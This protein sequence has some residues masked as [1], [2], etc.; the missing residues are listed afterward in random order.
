M[1]LKRMLPRAARRDPFKYFSKDGPYILDRDHAARE[2]VSRIMGPDSRINDEL[3]WFAKV[4]NLKK[5]KFCIE[6]HGGAQVDARCLVTGWTALH[7]AA[8]NADDHEETEH[9]KIVRYL[10][11]EKNA[12]LHAAAFDGTTPTELASGPTR[13]F[14]ERWDLEVKRRERQAM[15]GIQKRSRLAKDSPAWVSLRSTGGNYSTAEKG[16]GIGLEQLM[17]PSAQGEIHPIQSIQHEPQLYAVSPI[18]SVTARK[19]QPTPLRWKKSHSILDTVSTSHYS[20][21]DDEET[22]TYTASL[23]PESKRALL[24]ISTL[25]NALNEKLRRA[26]SNGN[27][28]VIRFLVLDE[29]ISPN[30]RA[31]LTGWTAMHY[32]AYANE[33]DALEFLVEHGDGN[34]MVKTADGKTV[35]DVAIR[36]IGGKH[37]NSSKYIRKWMRKEATRLRYH[38]NASKTKAKERSRMKPKQA[39]R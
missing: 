20:T 2:N 36:G 11:T 29:K 34:P 3:R 21:N 35:G 38:V 26:S 31:K 27:M 14:M 16:P 18:K 6:K 9:E 39:W 30:V 23:T 4:G 22:R 28:P 24:S 1:S 25:S 7:F 19:F 8:H 10:L 17:E 12:C 32:A 5:V 13:T 33:R 15:V 37:G